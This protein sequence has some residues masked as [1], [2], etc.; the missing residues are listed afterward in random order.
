MDREALVNHLAG[1]SIGTD[2]YPL[3]H[4]YMQRRRTIEHLLSEIEKAGWAIVPH[5]K[6]KP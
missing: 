6:V 3:P 1:K 4:N 5:L 2:T